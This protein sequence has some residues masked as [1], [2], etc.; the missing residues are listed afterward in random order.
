MSAVRRS[1]VGRAAGLVGL[2]ALAPAVAA[3]SGSSGNSKVS[4]S[5]SAGPSGVTASVSTSP[6]PSLTG[7]NGPLQIGQ[8]VTLTGTVAQVLIPGGY[9]FTM[10]ATGQSQPIAV[11]AF[12]G[13]SVKAGDAV[14]V[15]GTVASVDVQQLVKQFGSQLTPTAKTELQKLNGSKIVNATGVTPGGSGG[16]ASASA[17]AS[18]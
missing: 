7:S 6:L 12:T 1:R 13:S 2:L 15:K 17:S 3:C 4:A 10:N 16:S 18:S 11:G 5:V 14:T 9:I 8:N